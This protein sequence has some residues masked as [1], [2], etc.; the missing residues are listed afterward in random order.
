MYAYT[1]ACPLTHR[2][3]QRQRDTETHRETEIESETEA[4][5]GQ[6]D[7]D[8]EVIILSSACPPPPLIDRT[9]VTHTTTPTHDV[10]HYACSVS[11]DVYVQGVVDVT[12]TDGATWTSATIL[13]AREFLRSAVSVPRNRIL[14]C[15]F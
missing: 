7:R 5:R 13:C 15:V 2:D 14:E 11:T 8:S 9:T 3:R 1:Q 10:G 6:T 12:C 4:D